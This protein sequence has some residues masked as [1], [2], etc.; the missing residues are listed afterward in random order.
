MSAEEAGVTLP[1]LV[2]ESTDPEL[3]ALVAAGG[4]EARPAFQQVYER[5]AERVFAFLVRFLGDEELAKD[6]LQETF[7]RFHRSIPDHTATGSIQAWLFRVSRNAGIDLIRKQAKQERMVVERAKRLE[8]GEDE[9]V[10]ADA[11]RRERVA[12]TREALTR[13]PADD[14]AL[15]LQRHGLSM[16]VTDLAESFACTER[17]V[18]NRLR[19]AASRLA[20]AVTE[21]E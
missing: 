20:A 13:I 4:P 19:R 14:R 6:A 2:K 5:H 11:S 1:I 18:R 17:T 16:R 21:Q 12:R 3:V 10:V 9:S 7:L 15:L 8:A